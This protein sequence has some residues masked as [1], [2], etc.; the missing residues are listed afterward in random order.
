MAKKKS[1]DALDNTVSRD[2]WLA[3]YYVFEDDTPVSIDALRKTK[4]GLWKGVDASRFGR[5]RDT[6][7]YVEGRSLTC[8]HCNTAY[9]TRLRRPKCPYCHREP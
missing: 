6:D 7:P 4:F 3:D 1:E 2:K 8:Q 9:N 5:T